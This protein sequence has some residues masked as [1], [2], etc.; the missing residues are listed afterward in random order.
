M[1]KRLQDA[2]L[3]IRLAVQRIEQLVQSEEEG[4][5]QRER[6]LEKAY[7]ALSNHARRLLLPHQKALTGA[8]PQEY[9]R[10]ARA[11][12][13]QLIRLEIVFQPAPFGVETQAHAQTMTWNVQP[14]ESAEISYQTFQRVYGCSR[15][16]IDALISMLRSFY[17]TLPIRNRSVEWGVLKQRDMEA[18]DLLAMAFEERKSTPWQPQNV[19]WWNDHAPR[20]QRALIALSFAEW[21][22]ASSS[23]GGEDDHEHWL[24]TQSEAIL[25]GS[26][27]QLAD[28]LNWTKK[29]RVPENEPPLVLPHAVGAFFTLIHLSAGDRDGL[30]LVWNRLSDLSDPQ[31]LIASVATYYETLAEQKLPLQDDEALLHNIFGQAH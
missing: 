13:S 11:L 21:L 18:Q 27:A 24:I 22:S 7:G 26:V 28:W 29:R 1:Y 30:D 6:A 5:E 14:E 17:P 15:Q 19:S 23:L 2:G 9:L 16:E 25:H 8:S 31:T 4:L 10:G 12:L 20:R 3:R